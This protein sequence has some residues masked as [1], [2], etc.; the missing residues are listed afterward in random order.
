MNQNAH[1]RP[2]FDLWV[3]S[4]DRDR[5]WLLGPIR[6]TGNCCERETYQPNNETS[7]DLPVFHGEDL[8]TIG[9]KDVP[10]LLRTA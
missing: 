2:G 6:L 5:K 4:R 1:L 7:E 3:I 8:D 9:S 10:E